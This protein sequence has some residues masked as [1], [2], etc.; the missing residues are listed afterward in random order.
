MPMPETKEAKET[1]NVNY[2]LMPAEN[3]ARVHQSLHAPK[4]ERKGINETK[5]RNAAAKHE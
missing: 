4:K 2:L 5:P 1:K 3:D